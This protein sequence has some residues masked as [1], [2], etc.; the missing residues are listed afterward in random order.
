[1][2]ALSAIA[3]RQSC[4]TVPTEQAVHLL[5][6]YVATYPADGIVYRSSDMI[7]CTHADAGFLNETN[8]RSRAGAHIFLSENDP[9]P[10]FN[11][12]ILSI[13]QIIK[14]VMASAAESELAALFITA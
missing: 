13:A 11:G 4:A 7:L 8:S 6:D 14:F 9:F 5:L 12:A 3:A 10:R 2:V 1:L